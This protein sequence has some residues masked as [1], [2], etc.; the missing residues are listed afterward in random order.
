MNPFF[1]NY[2][3]WDIF[4]KIN[5][6]YIRDIVLILGKIFI[7]KK[8][9]S[10]VSQK[11]YY[12]IMIACDSLE[13]NKPLGMCSLCCCMEPNK[14]YILDENPMSKLTFKSMILTEYGY[15]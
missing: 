12:V 13:T 7:L 4:K 9:N 8:K 6:L 14:N 15:A 10:V 1:P 5:S 11:L 2:I 3:P